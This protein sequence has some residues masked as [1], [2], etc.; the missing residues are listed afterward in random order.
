MWIERVGGNSTNHIVIV[1]IIWFSGNIY[2]F[3]LN[4][5]ACAITNGSEIIRQE[6]RRF[7]SWNP[8]ISEAL[9]YFF[10]NTGDIEE[11]RHAIE[12]RLISNSSCNSV[13]YL[14]GDNYMDTSGLGNLIFGFYSEQF[15]VTLEDLASNIAQ[16]GN[17]NSLLSFLDN[18]DDFSQRRTGRE[19]AERFDS[20]EQLTTSLIESSADNND[21][22]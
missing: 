2:E 15:S 4:T 13:Y 7:M 12:D 19:I 1:S 20:G 22:Q 5:R 9:N 6:I 16:G 8:N 10:P 3:D 18:P 11:F 17:R 14:V 21:L